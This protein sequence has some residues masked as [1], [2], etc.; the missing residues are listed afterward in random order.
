AEL[1]RHFPRLEIGALLGR[2]ASGSVWRARQLELSRDVA[3]KILSPELSREPAFEARFEREARAL[4]SLDHPRIVKVHDYGKAG[5]YA[6]LVMELVEGASLRDLLREGRLEKSEIL[7]LA[8][9]ICSALAYAHARGVVHRDIK[10]ENLLVDADGRA[11]VADFGLAKL[12]GPAATPSLR[13][14]GGERVGTPLYMAPEQLEKP[15]SVDHRADLYSLGVVLYELLTGE[16]PI[17]RFDAPS[18]RGSPDARYDSVVLRALE[19]DP[20]RRQQGAAEV[21][22]ELEAASR[23]ALESTRANSTSDAADRAPERSPTPLVAAARLPGSAQAPGFALYYLLSLVFVGLSLL[24]VST[25]LRNVLTVV[26]MFGVG[27]LVLQALLAHRG[28]TRGRALLASISGVLVGGA[29]AILLTTAAFL[30]TLYVDVRGIQLADIRFVQACS[31][32][33]VLGGAYVCLRSVRRALRENQQRRAGRLYGGILFVMLYA[34]FGTLRF[35]DGESHARSMCFVIGVAFAVVDFWIG[36]LD[37]Q[38]QGPLLCG[39]RGA[40]GWSVVLEAGGKRGVNWIRAL[41]TATGCTLAQA[42][43]ARRTNAEWKALLGL[44]E[45]QARSITEQLVR[46]GLAARFEQPAQHQDQESESA[47]NAR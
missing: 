21:G 28:S 15:A 13:S 17:G 24:P 42:N 29:T 19:K 25:A 43:A 11:K 31:L 39:P 23:A 32:L 3:L 1:A 46:A 6:F 36:R 10:P 33:A 37:A 27:F 14:A 16:L 44:E 18:K 12:V 22:S 35:A 20:A 7:T 40:R 47:S 38:I 45:A 8:S 9:D 2:G 26:L 34:F 4:A 5:P 41:R 30:R